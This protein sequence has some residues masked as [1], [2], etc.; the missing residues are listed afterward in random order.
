MGLRCFDINFL[1]D[2]VL[3]LSCFLFGL[4]AAVDTCLLVHP[5]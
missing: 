4:V 2:V 3:T 5:L 1:S